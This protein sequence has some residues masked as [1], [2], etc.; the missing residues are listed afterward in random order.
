MTTGC[1]MLSIFK[2]KADDPTLEDFFA[3]AQKSAEE[4]EFSINASFESKVL[5]STDEP[6][7]TNEFYAKNSNSFYI[8][9]E[10]YD[11]GVSKVILNY[12]K[13]R[14]NK[15]GDTFVDYSSDIMV[16]NSVY[17][18]KYDFDEE[19]TAK[20]HDVDV[21][22]DSLS[23]STKADKYA[24]TTTFNTVKTNGF[25]SDNGKSYE[26]KVNNTFDD[27]HGYFSTGAK[28]DFT[29]VNAYLYK[30]NSSSN[31]KAYVFAT[32]YS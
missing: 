12:V 26:L 23:S 28:N 32:D 17:E 1:D 16:E 22:Y 3:A 10:D 25:G 29:E 13:N 19:R 31:C 15:E 11:S 18:I 5:D 4:D 30:I 2:G 9:N 27:S 7:K 14:Q 20:A 8:I 24:V 21:F 6:Y